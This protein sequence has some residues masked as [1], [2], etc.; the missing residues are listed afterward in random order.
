MTYPNPPL[1]RKLEN[2]RLRRIYL[3]QGGSSEPNSQDA[4][5]PSNSVPPHSDARR[6]PQSGIRS[7]AIL[8]KAARDAW[9]AASPAR[10]CR[11]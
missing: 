10:F 8:E 3:S 11:S 9:K 6:R 1:E 2:D 5:H 4:S 7:D